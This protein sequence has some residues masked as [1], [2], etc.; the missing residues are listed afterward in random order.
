MDNENVNGQNKNT[1]GQNRN[2][3]G[4]NKN[5]YGAN[6]NIHGDNENVHGPNINVYGENKNVHGENFWID[7]ASGQ[8]RNTRRPGP[9]LSKSSYLN[10]ETM[11]ATSQIQGKQL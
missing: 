6:I 9:P 4:D 8:L 5:V 2:K 3:N 11:D 10:W 1:F 7:L